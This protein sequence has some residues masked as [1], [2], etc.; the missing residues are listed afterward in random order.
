MKGVMQIKRVFID[1]D[2]EPLKRRLADLAGLMRDLGGADID[3][4]D[5]QRPDDENQNKKES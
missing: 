5:G 2:A 3:I 4:K 1:A